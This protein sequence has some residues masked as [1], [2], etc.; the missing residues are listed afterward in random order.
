MGNKLGNGKGR[1]GVR[2]YTGLIIANKYQIG[3]KLG[4][5][6]GADAYAC[7]NI[8]SKGEYC[9]KVL[10]RGYSADASG[11]AEEL[12]NE[13][14]V[15]RL[16]AHV[17]NT[18]KLYELVIKKDVPILITDLCKGGELF[19]RLVNGPIKEQECKVIFRD[20]LRCIEAV[21]QSGYLH[22]NIQPENI[23]MLDNSSNKFRLGGFS[24]ACKIERAS[25]AC[26]APGYV[27]P[28]VISGERKRGGYSC[29]AD[30]W[31][32]G[33]VFFICLFGYPPFFGDSD[34]EQMMAIKTEEPAFP[35]SPNAPNVSS[36]AVDFV[37]SIIGEK[38]EYKRPDIR[39]LLNS[40]FLAGVGGGDGGGGWTTSFAEPEIK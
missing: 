40:P 36:Q 30:V 27:A 33:V 25:D 7:T 38:D 5:G 28:E 35:Q 14:N 37:K 6:T 24:L 10:K 31:S 34:K 19:E 32:L 15:L 22:R 8:V 4:E 18:I 12:S 23:F 26:G 2:G 20:L 1:R 13:V 11:R 16:L 3:K 21:H 17:P 9:A 39:T 29:P